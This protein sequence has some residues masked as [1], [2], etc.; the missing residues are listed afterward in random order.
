MLSHAPVRT[1]AR[2]VGI[3]ISICSLH[4]AAWAQQETSGQPTSQASEVSSSPASPAHTLQGYAE[5][6]EGSARL[7]R[8]LS[9]SAALPETSLQSSVVDTKD[10]QSP[11]HALLPGSAMIGPTNNQPIVGSAA[12]GQDEY[13]V[14]WDAW[15]HRIADAVW[16]KIQGTRMWGQ[17]KVEYN[18]TR[19]HRIFITHIE[20]PDPSGESGRFLAGAITTL[21]GSPLLEFPQGSHQTVH[22]N[23]NAT[24]GRP[25]PSR[26]SGVVHL[27]GGTEHVFEKW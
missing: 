11:A 17:T 7:Q 1:I 12:G 22:H 19:D 10:F 5:Q 27:P 18:V 9:G 4:V 16:A 24:M 20:T 25:V 21:D 6:S 14:N 23:A 13:W 15:R 3:T 26:L 2:L 8:P